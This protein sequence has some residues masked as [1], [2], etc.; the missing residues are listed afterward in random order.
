M[1]QGRH[2]ESEPGGQGQHLGRPRGGRTE[3]SA[4]LKEC[5]AKEQVEIASGG[6]RAGP[7]PASLVSRDGNHCRT[8]LKGVIQ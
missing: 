4:K 1:S 2:R 8:L 5:V 6:T 7:D 3:R